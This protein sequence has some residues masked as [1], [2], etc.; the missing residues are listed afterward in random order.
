MKKLTYI[1]PK[2]KY[3]TEGV[4]GRVAHALGV[5]EGFHHNGWGVK[6]VSGPEAERYCESI[7]PEVATVDFSFNSER[8]GLNSI[9]SWSSSD[10]DCDVLQV[11]YAASLP[12]FLIR[13]ARISNALGLISVLEVNSFACHNLQDLPQLARKLLLRIECWIASHF[14]YVYVVSEELKSQLVE[15]GCSSTVIVVPNG[16]SKHLG[17]G[18]VSVKPDIKRVKFVYLGVLQPYYDYRSLVDAYSRVRAIK[19][20]SVSLEI[21]GDGP[22]LSKLE[23]LCSGVDGVTLHGR[24][25]IKD[26]TA[27]INPETDIL[28]LPYAQA[29]AGTI[30]SPIKL[31]E[32]MAL[33]CPVVASNVGQIKSIL[34]HRNTGYLYEASNVSS[35]ADTLIEVM[36]DQERLLV[37]NSA[38]RCFAEKYT[39]E[40]RMGSLI[41]G[42]SNVST[43]PLRNL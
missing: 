42:I 9:L 25:D 4:R 32:Y 34:A 39:W 10:F 40:V 14:S 22:M 5:I 11:R 24:Y 20:D 1:L 41:D 37:A 17:R 33:N 26:L 6:V 28:V 19:G 13:L 16:A 23:A 2:K 18:P 36:I 8:S 43:E 12:L 27:R 21:H 15:G 29:S 31:Y 3:F 38:A 30:H 7:S 35:F